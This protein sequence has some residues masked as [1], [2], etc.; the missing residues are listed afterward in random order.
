MN[1][2]AC[3]SALA[4]KRY[5]EIV[6]DVCPKC[7]GVWFDRRELS[8]FIDL[9]L[10]DH[11]DL[12]DSTIQLNK[13]VTSVAAVHEPRRPCPSCEEQL[14]KVNYAYDSNIIVDKCLS[15][16]GVWVDRPELKQLAVYAKGNPKLTKMGASL[17]GYVAEVEQRRE[18]TEAAQTLSRNAGI[19]VCMPKIILPVGDDAGRRRFPAV[20][21]GIILINVT[22]LVWMFVSFDDWSPVFAALGFVPKIIMT[23][24]E[25][26]RFIT[27]IF[28]H[29]GVLHLFG[30]AL[31]LWI[32]GDN[33]EDAFGHILFAAFYL[34]CGIAGALAFMLPH[35]ASEI[36]GIGASGAISGVMGAYFVL[37]PQARVKTF[38]V[39]TVVA[40]PAYVYLGGWF[41]FQLLFTFLCGAYEPVGFSAHA[42]GFAAGIVIALCYKALRSRRAKTAQASPTSR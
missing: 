15:C 2:P 6:L 23:G 7:R 41:A 3:H 20:T 34:L 12:P 40:I 32:F 36:P 8:D 39:F 25:H 26:F 14:I 38:V 21:L 29:G 35:M 5:R 13:S 28:L 33:V 37:Y 9:Y 42:G 30:N 4:K 22:V 19:L 24:Q 18:L 31:F 27:S 17:A 11:E 1:C 10:Q 16:N